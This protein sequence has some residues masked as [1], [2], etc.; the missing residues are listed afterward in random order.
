ML[1]A[2]V[3]GGLLDSIACRLG[4]SPLVGSA[5]SLVMALVPVRGEG[6]GEGS[7]LLLLRAI[8]VHR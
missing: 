4:G 7:L 1:G 3:V 8:R 5:T 2:R 6:E